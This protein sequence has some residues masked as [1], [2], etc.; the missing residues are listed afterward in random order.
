MVAV[1]QPRDLTDVTKVKDART[2]NE[3]M[4]NNPI[5]LTKQQASSTR[6]G[7]NKK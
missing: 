1:L 4:M 3:E 2:V 6:L 7:Y 5:L